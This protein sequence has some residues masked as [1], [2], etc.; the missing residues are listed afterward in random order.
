M[1]KHLAPYVQA[2]LNG[3]PINVEAKRAGTYFTKLRNLVMRH[4]D[5]EKAKAEGLLHK[6]GLPGVVQVSVDDATISQAV[7]EVFS[8]SSVTSTG[9]KYGIAVSTLC[10]KVK[11]AHPD[12]DL[13]KGKLMTLR[14]AEKGLEEAKEALA[15]AK[16]RVQELSA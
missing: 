10:R 13:G 11:K 7:A 14:K 3:S 16:R 4:P 5:Y 6:P 9:A 15:K 12:I 8:G 1:S 2:V